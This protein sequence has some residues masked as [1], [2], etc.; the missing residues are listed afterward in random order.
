ML[1]PDSEVGKRVRDAAYM[2]DYLRTHVRRC[3]DSDGCLLWAGYCGRSGPTVVWRYRRHQLRRL[4]HELATGKPLPDSVVIWPGCGNN[5]CV[6]EA[7][8][9]IGTR[10]ARNS[11][12][13]SAPG[14]VRRATGVAASV[15]GARAWSKRGGARLPMSEYETVMRLRGEGMI[16]REI[17]ARYG[18]TA[19]RVEQAIKR[20][21]RVF[22]NG[23]VR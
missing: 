7:H 5:R 12:L 3:Q 6:A 1:T 4:L 10:S 14:A 13:T 17:G 15:N 20:W 16:Y 19:A 9:K 2:L 22:G 23:A 18:V 11:V 8:F 21:A